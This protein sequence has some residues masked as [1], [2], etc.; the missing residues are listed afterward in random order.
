MAP[1]HNGAGTSHTPGYPDGSLQ[2]YRDS[3]IPFIEDV[4]QSV[5]MP[6]NTQEKLSEVT[7]N[8]K[9]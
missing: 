5:V 3:F 9:I 4:G 7:G 2:K 6:V 8:R 1:A